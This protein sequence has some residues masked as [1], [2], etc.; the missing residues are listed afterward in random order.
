MTGA[1]DFMARGIE[2]PDDFTIIAENIHATRIVLRNGRRATTLEEGTEAVTFKGESGDS[3]Y[4]RIPESFKST[5]PYEQG[6]IKHFMIAMHK[7]ISDNPAE[8]AEGAAYVHYEAWR[9]AKAG[10]HFMDLNADEISYH[11]EIQKNAMA[12]LVR[13]T[14]EVSPVPPSVDSSNPEI[15]AAGLAEYD[16]RAGRPLLNS[17]ALER[18][19]TLDLVKEHNSRVIVTAAGAEG[20][21]Q[22]A[23]ERVANV[24]QLMEAVQSA[25]IPLSDVYIDCLVFPIAVDPQYGNHYLDAVREIRKTY[26]PE[27]H[28]T[29]GLSNVSFGLPKRKLVNDTF[30]YLSL[31]AGVDSGI[32]DPIQSKIGEVFN[33][34]VDSEGVRLAREMLLGEDEFCVNYIQAWR[35][36]KL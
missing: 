30:I 16:G 19:E 3:L 17:V 4:L 35:D 24:K 8:Q 26:G 7:G 28:I 13:T 36:G 29:G 15:I 2:S 10:A 6:Q 11:L 31:E 33:L 18:L 25:G 34:D 22:D 21:P 23:E 1:T 32:I 27:V 9:Q 5:Q 20:M 14:Q 12:W